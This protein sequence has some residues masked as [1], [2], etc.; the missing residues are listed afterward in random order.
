MRI[1]GVDYGLKRIGLAVGE[2]DVNMAFP[3]PT[4]AASGQAERDA[5]AIAELVREEGFD[6]V[7]LGLPLLPS[8]D[9][10]D[11][12]RIVRSLGD[13]LQALGV[14]IRYVDERGTTRQAHSTLSEIKASKRKRLLDGEAARI[15]V[16][17]FLRAAQ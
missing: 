12:A 5:A 2:T 6:L 17:E 1:L 8:G 7:V 4:L 11:Q 10:G 13:A 9:E 15:L 14:P 3:R 16:E